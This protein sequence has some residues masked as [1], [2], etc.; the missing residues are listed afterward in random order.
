MLFDLR[1]RGRRRTVRVIYLGLAVIFLLG[2]VGFGVG[3]GGS[4]GGLFNALTENNGGGS[5]SFAGKVAAAQKR[6]NREPN[7][8]Q[9]LAALI[10]AQF[11]QASEGTYY[12]QTTEAYTSQGKQLLA[13]V[14]ETWNKYLAL[15]PHNPSPSLARQ[16][17]ERVFLEAGLNQPS[18]ALQAWQIVVAAEPPTAALYG[19]L[20][21]Y[22]YKAHNT[23]VGDLASEKAVNLAPASERKRIKEEL[24]AIKKNPSGSS[25]SSS[26]VPSGTYTATVNGKKT[27]IKSS[28]NGTVTAAGG[29]SSATGS[30]G[31]KK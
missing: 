3:V 20:A 22:A 18:Q 23:N 24:E 27:V 14:A 12:D 7:N 4:G 13:K 2:F 31:A 16:M 28:G 25:S 17:T 15:E 29:S 19:T 30:S 9:A 11:H 5:A 26:T 6:V 8:P 10:E 21:E 1:G